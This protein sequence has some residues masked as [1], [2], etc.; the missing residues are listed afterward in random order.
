MESER[1]K[2]GWDKLKE[3]D[4]RAGERIVDALKDIAPDLA[5]YVI[6]FPFGVNSGRC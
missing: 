5:R 6:E 3:I 2:R 1:F 4:G